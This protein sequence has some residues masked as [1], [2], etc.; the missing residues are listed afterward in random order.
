MKGCHGGVQR[1]GKGYHTNDILEL[2][3]NR[4]GIRGKK[5][6][7]FDGDM[8]NVNSPRLMTFKLKGTTCY[9]CG[10]EGVVFFKERTADKD[11][12]HFNLYGYDSEGNEVLMTK[13][14][15]ISKS[16]GGNNHIN[17][18]K[19][20]CKLCNETKSNMNM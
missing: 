9:M 8:V 7:D 15:I 4:F 3:P 16:R 2:I 14:H 13:D 1:K 19:T 17:N 10:I 18:F 6:L 12:Y 5:R 11:S 20:M